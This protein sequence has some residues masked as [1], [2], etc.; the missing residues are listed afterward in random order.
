MTWYTIRFQGQTYTENLVG[1]SEK[2]MTALGI[3]GYATEAEA[4]A[5]PQT[6]NALQGALGGAQ[7]LGGVSGSV[8]NI[9]TPGSIVTGGATA[10]AAATTPLQWLQSLFTRANAVRLAEGVLGLALVLVA[11]AKLAEGS[12]AGN[13]AKKVPFI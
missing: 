9:D 11:V 4:E 8:T 12:P 2:T 5:H 1:A 13:L 10:A 6:M 7:A 3:H